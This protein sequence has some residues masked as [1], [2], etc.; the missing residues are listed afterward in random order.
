MPGAVA[1][2]EDA[3]SL[4]KWDDRLDP[5]R[6]LAEGD[7]PRGEIVSE[8]QPVVEPVEVDAQEAGDQSHGKQ[9]KGLTAFDQTLVAV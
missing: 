8:R 5:V 6:P 1:E 3:R 2:F 4:D 9:N 7:R